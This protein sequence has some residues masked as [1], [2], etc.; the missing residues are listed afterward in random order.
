MADNLL[1]GAA[2]FAPVELPPEIARLRVLDERAAA[3][4]VGLSAASLERL[5]KAGTAPR[6]VSL[7][8]RRLG[9]RVAD[10]IAWLDSRASTDGKA[11]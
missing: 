4:F 11:A 10:L 9:Y 5:R 1:S 6:H 3:Q 2:I 7:S 8:P